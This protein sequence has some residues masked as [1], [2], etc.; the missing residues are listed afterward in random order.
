MNMKYF[1]DSYDIVKQS[2][3]RWLSVFGEWTVH[4][5]FSEQ[6]SP[7][8]NE[9]YSKLIGARVISDEIITARTD[10]Q[11][12]F[13]PAGGCA[14]LFLDPDT[15]LSIRTQGKYSSQYLYTG[16]LVAM[17]K[18]RTGHLT[19]VFDQSVARGSEKESLEK[20]LRHLHANGVNA[21]A[22]ISHACFILCS[23]NQAELNKALNH[24]LKE[25]LLPESRFMCS[26]DL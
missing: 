22:Y 19:L 4:P 7:Q 21:V 12:Y 20:K 14:N 9:C 6:V 17:V 8:D 23:N 11:K 15:G 26:W 2:L 5:M 13:E 3:L 10:R 18:K 25:S 1:G 24:L 16:E